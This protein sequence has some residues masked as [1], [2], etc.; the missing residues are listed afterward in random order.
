MYD[1]TIYDLEGECSIIYDATGIDVLANGFFRV[2]TESTV[3]M[4]NPN[5]IEKIEAEET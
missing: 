4:L 2:I 5:T 1:V 3:T